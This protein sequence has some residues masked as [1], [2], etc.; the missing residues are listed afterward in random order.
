MNQTA[1]LAVASSIPADTVF[2]DLIY[3]PEETVFLR[4]GQITGHR[5]Q[6]GKAMIVCQAAIAFCKRLCVDEIRTCGLDEREAYSRVV[7]AMCRVW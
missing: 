5:T 2:Y 1:S 6:N 7:E 4:H 3:F